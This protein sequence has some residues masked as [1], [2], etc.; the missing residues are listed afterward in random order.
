MRCSCHSTK[1]SQC[2]SDWMQWCNLGSPQ[3]LPPW[4]KRFSCLSLPSSWDYRCLLPY[5]VIYLFICIFV[6]AVFYY[7]GL[8]SLKLLTSGN[9]P[10]LAFQSAGI[11]GMTHSGR[12]HSTLSLVQ[13]QCPTPIMPELWE[14]KA[15]ELLEPRSSRPALE[16]Y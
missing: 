7:V 5:L 8:A 1:I 9:L 11:T 2:C 15:R 4:F 12:P 3:P 16:T 10:A 13:A 14:A 6:E